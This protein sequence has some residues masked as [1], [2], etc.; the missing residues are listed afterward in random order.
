V[1]SENNEV[2]AFVKFNY[3]H[4]E[5]SKKWKENPSKI[6]NLYYNDQQDC[7]YC[8]MGQKMTFVR[9]STRTTDNGYKQIKR[10]YQAQNCKGCPMR[11]PCHKGKT[12]ELSK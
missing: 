4:K 9:E 11:G 12:T 5:Q 8:P 7:Y 2:E 10:Y 3:F 1:I 6:E